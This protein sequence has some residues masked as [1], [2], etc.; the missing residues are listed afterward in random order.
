MVLEKSR[1]LRGQGRSPWLSWY[2]LLGENVEIKS[3][4][5]IILRICWLKFVRRDKKVLSDVRKLIA[6]DTHSVGTETNLVAHS[7][8]KK[9][10]HVATHFPTL[11]SFWDG[12]YFHALSMSLKKS[13]NSKILPQMTSKFTEI[14]QNFSEFCELNEA[15]LTSWTCYAIVGVSIDK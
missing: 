13:E 7:S 1:V 15:F 8:I 10:K 9:D 4:K 14:H 6:D 11:K 2:I 3:L 5:I 12:S